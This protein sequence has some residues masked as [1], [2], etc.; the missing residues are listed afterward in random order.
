MFKQTKEGVLI[1]VYVKPNSKE[2]KIVGVN[3]ERRRIVIKISEPARKGRCNKHLLKFLSKLTGK[4]VVIL[5]G[6]KSKEKDILIE[7][8]EL[9]KVKEKLKI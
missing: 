1:K 7:N 9:D 2:D 8:V 4:R 5:R 3:K 6:E